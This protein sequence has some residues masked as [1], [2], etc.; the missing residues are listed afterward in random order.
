MPTFVRRIRTI[1]IAT[2]A[3]LLLV[4]TQPVVLLAAPPPIAAKN[5]IV[6]DPDTN[7]ELFARASRARVAPAS[8]TK[9][10]T[11]LVAV[12]RADPARQVAILPEDLI[13]EATMGLRAG[14]TVSLGTLLYGL[15]LPSGND[16]AMAIARGVGAR[17]DDSSGAEGVARFVGWMNETAARLDLRDTHFVNPH[18]LDAEDHYSSAYDLARLTGAAWQQPTFARTFGS[19]SYQGEGHVLRHGNRLIG[20]YDG[21]VGGKT[22][23]TDGCGFC[24]VTT[25]Q[26]A[27]HRLVVV[28]LRDTK[29]GAFADTA[30]LLGWSYA[31]LEA[32]VPVAAPPPPTAIPVAPTPVPAGAA[33]VA[34]ATGQRAAVPVVTP[35]LVVQNS[36]PALAPA[37]VGAAPAG[38]FEQIPS[39]P[40]ALLALGVALL[41]CWMGGGFG[42]VAITRR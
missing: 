38:L 9:I 42:R 28:V 14:E 19:A 21:V 25:A 10:M 24:L 17:A 11:A 6:L 4:L 32:P 16:A 3:T 26:H 1:L 15:L 34:P 31:Q 39:T 41:L 23:L 8:L 35:G 40:I 33:N 2:I 30:A 27:E 13:G 12:Q 18:G 29:E 20:Q 5:A 36:Q 22:G 7:R 37:R